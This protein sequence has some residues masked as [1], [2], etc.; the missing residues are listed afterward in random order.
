VAF[1]FPVL[2]PMRDDG[3]RPLNRETADGSILALLGHDRSA[4]RRDKRPIRV[5][6]YYQ[7]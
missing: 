3:K 7:T 1:N 4:D 2:L 5:I 6:A